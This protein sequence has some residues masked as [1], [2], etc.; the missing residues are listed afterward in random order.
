MKEAT[1]LQQIKAMCKR[2]ALILPM[3]RASINMSHHIV[4]QTLEEVSSTTDA[5]RGIS[6]LTSVVT[7]GRGGGGLLGQCSAAI[8]LYKLWAGLVL[9]GGQSV[10]FLAPIGL[11][12]SEG[13]AKQ[14]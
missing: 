11:P 14:G 9:G 10:L 2:Q 6:L 8:L 12:L 1:D 5:S 3:E 4:L 13:C 7:R